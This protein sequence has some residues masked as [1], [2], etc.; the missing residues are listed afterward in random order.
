MFCSCSRQASYV[1][2][3]AYYTCHLPIWRGLPLSLVSPCT[4]YMG[5]VSDFTPGAPEVLNQ[6]LPYTACCFFSLDETER[7]FRNPYTCLM[8]LGLHIHFLPIAFTN[9]MAQTN[10]SCMFM[11]LTI[12]FENIHKPFSG[13]K[14]FSPPEK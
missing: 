4:L 14:N 9:T 12:G 11:C 7:G 5:P 6:R 2:S 3:L 8:V 13:N 1:T 10:A